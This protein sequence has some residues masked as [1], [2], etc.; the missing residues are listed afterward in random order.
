MVW[1][2]VW[3]PSDGMDEM[4]WDGMGGW[5]GWMSGRIDVWMGLKGRGMD[6]WD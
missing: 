6:G 3:I 2:W 4:G 1:V 5:M